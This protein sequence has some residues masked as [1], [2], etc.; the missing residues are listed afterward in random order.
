M[1]LTPIIQEKIEQ[2]SFLLQS[3]LD[4][5]FLDCYYEDCSRTELRSMSDDELNILPYNV[6]GLLNKQ[7]ELGD[8]LSNCGGKEIHIATINEM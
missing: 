2:P 6:R 3:K 8:L 4:L 5:D 1:C 7:K